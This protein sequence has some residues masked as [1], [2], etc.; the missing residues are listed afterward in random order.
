MINTKKLKERI[1]CIDYAQRIGLPV[2]K[3]KPRCASPLRAGATNKTSFYVGQ[4]WFCDYGGDA[5]GDVIDLCAAVNHDGDKG[6]AIRELA[7]ITGIADDNEYSSNWLA[8]MQN[9]ANKV[10]RWHEA[11]N[12]SDKQYLAD[13]KIN[14]NCIETLKIGALIENGERRIVIPYW[15]NQ[16]PVYYISRGNDPKYKKAQIDNYNEHVIFGLDTLK[17]EHDTLI[18]TEGCFDLLSFWQEDYCV[19]GTMGGY[20]N[21]IQLNTLKDICGNFKKVILCFDNDKAGKRFTERMSEFLFRNHIKFYVAEIPSEYGKDVSDYYCN[22]GNLAELI[23]NAKLGLAHMIQ[24]YK[25]ENEFEEF[26]LGCRKY[27]SKTDYAL[28]FAEAEDKFNKQWLK[29]LKKICLSAPSEKDI[30]DEVIN[31]HILLY[32]PAQGFLEYSGTHYDR[33]P[34]DHIK[35]YI[36]KAF[37]IYATGSRVNGTL[38]LIKSLTV[39]NFEFNNT[40]VVNFANG[41]LDLKTMKLRKH[42]ASDLI[43]YCLDYEYRPRVKSKK[44][45]QFIDDVTDGATDK[46]DLLQE[47]CGYILFPDNRFQQCLCLI[48]EGSNGKSVFCKIMQKVFPNTTDIEMHDLAKDFNSIRLMDSML[49]IAAE[50]K[51]NV[52]GAEERFKQVI[53]GSSIS[54]SFKGKDKISF[55]PRAKWIIAANHFVK[56]KDLSEGWLRRFI[57]M[58][59]TVSFV[60]TP[61]RLHEKKKNKNLENEL[62]RKSELTGIF[63]WLL[64]GYV[65][66]NQNG[67]FTKTEESGQLREE[68]I[69]EVNPVVVFG[70]E[71]EL[72]PGEFISNVDLYEEYKMWS[73]RNNHK[74]LSNMSFHKRI[75][76]YFN[77]YEPDVKV[78]RK[79]QGRG[80]QK[81]ES[82]ISV[83]KLF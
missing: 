81:D 74:T 45:I 73:D 23:R 14:N 77:K 75:K 12:E 7:E 55:K 31:E 34:D 30:A 72:E 65:R 21:K 26:A 44:W 8:Y 37:G 43:T 32:A 68:Y 57:M 52:V 51:S 35:S 36:T 47:Y 80:Y 64:E 28:I 9:L 19:V 5:H 29:E 58:K 69:E 3:T 62:S 15:S 66:L 50:T 54:D 41:T 10:Q 49:N 78:V 27:T 16:H 39:S 20:F 6:K 71:L 11:L 33:V 60:D 22:N 48:G 18:I 83:Q 1:N 40:S 56:G 42:S 4:E 25:T 61:T 13:R 76:D 63:N 2:S 46:A 59:F 82:E 67:K 53:D 38:N 17:R 70:R 24:K 79:T